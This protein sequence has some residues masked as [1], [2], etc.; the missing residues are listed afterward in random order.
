MARVHAP[1]FKWRLFSQ[2]QSC[3][4][5]TLGFAPSHLPQIFRNQIID[6][7]VSTAFKA[8][9][10]AWARCI[11]CIGCLLGRNPIS[12]HFQWSSDH[13]PFKWVNRLF[14]KV[15]KTGIF[16]WFLPEKN[17]ITFLVFCMAS[18]LTR[19]IFW[20]WRCSPLF[21]GAKNLGSW[22][23]IFSHPILIFYQ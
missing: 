4:L 23:T 21:L 18:W 19:S 9:C 2:S 11:G 16:F 8:S 20:P 14:T 1:F 10:R 15:F 3:N 7:I 6:A 12:D 17:P 22:F 5:S 13:S